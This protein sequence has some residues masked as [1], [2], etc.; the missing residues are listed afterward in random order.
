MTS[1]LPQGEEKV[2]AVR[3]MF[4]TIAPR[5]DLVNRIMTFRLDVGWR[6]RAVRMLGL[7]PGSVVVDVAHGH[8]RS[9]AAHRQPDAVA[10]EHPPVLAGER[11]QV[12]RLV[13]RQRP[14]ARRQHRHERVPVSS[15]AMPPDNR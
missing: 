10:L 13:R 5:Y 4:D 11:Q 2:R 12:G 15:W 8:A 6:R 1:M 14:R 7:G 3:E 9:D